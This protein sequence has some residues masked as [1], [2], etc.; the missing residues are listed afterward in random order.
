MFDMKD[1]WKNYD[2]D[3]LMAA[4]NYFAEFLE[5]PD[6]EI[7]REWVMTHV[8]QQ[9]Y[10]PEIWMTATSLIMKHSLTRSQNLRKRFRRI[11]KDGIYF[12]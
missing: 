10:L 5:K 4:V 9:K 12:A 2:E 8:P 6:K 3:A 1:S 7:L 11:Q